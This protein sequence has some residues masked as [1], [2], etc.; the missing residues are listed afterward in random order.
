MLDPLA[1]WVLLGRKA[2]VVLVVMPAQ[3]VP[4]DLLVWLA[5]LVCREKREPLDRRVLQVLLAPLDP[6]VCLVLRALL[7][8]LA[9]EVTVVFLV[10]LG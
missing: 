7:V 9:Q 6:R 5:L 10:A 4:R 3:V 8:F 1:P 2:P